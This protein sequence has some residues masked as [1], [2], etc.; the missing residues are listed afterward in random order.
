MKRLKHILVVNEDPEAADTLA[1]LLELSNRPVVAH[2][3][4]TSSSAVILATGGRFN[5]IIL[6]LHTSGLDNLLAAQSIRLEKNRHPPKLIA[7]SNHSEQLAAISGRSL[8]DR[9]L[10]RSTSISSLLDAIHCF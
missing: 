5:I 10:P 1:L 8:F 7:L 9:I 3:A 6:S 2:T 4:Y